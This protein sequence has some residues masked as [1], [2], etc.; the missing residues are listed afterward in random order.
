MNGTLEKKSATG[1]NW[2]TSTNTTKWNF[3][4]YTRLI[5]P[6]NESHLVCEEARRFCEGCQMDVPQSEA[7]QLYQ[8][9]TQ[10]HEEIRICHYNYYLSSSGP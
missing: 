4:R 9:W 7:S 1:W 2:N 10:E 3:R 5:C 8:W 6:R